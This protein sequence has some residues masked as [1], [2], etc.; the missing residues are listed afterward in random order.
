MPRVTPSPDPEASRSSF[1]LRPGA[2]YRL[3]L[4]VWALRRRGLNRIDRWDGTYR[5]ALRAGG[6]VLG[7]RVRQTGS[8]R[9]PVLH[10]E[11]LGPGRRGPDQVSE[12]R[13]Q[14]SRLLGLDVELA[15]FYE[16]ADAD[17]RT[18]PLKERFLGVRP[19]RFPDLFEALVNAV[20]NQQLSLEVGLTL[21]NRLAEHLGD[22]VTGS[23]EAVAFPG[24]EAIRGASVETL[25]ALGFSRR[26]AGYLR[27]IARAMAA[28]EVDEAT[29]GRVGRVEAARRL[30]EI[31]GIGRWSAEYVLLR[32]LGRLEVYP[33]DDVGARHRLRRFF[34]LDHD[35]SYE[36]IADLL[37]PWAPFAG[38]LYF[39]MLLDGL[40]ERGDL[41]ADGGA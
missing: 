17:P 36:E 14:V 33:G 28:G 12:L 24:A 31:A 32:G 4:T 39:H 22:E 38:M 21:L 5:R 16:L 19:P 34:G 23:E 37:R 18:R 26:K 11:V 10:V 20:A 29:L 8:M 35:P 1:D 9:D 13:A 41:Q 40:A 3:D 27:G 6:D 25:R 15:P 7:V 2:P 30:Q